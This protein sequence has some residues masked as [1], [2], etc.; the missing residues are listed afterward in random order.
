MFLA[1]FSGLELNGASQKDGS[2]TWKL[3]SIVFVFLLV[4]FA[5]QVVSRFVNWFLAYWYTRTQ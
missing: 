3:K 4:Y 5:Y 2:V 1:E